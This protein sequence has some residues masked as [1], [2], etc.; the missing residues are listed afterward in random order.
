MAKTAS[1]I[2]GIIFIIAGVWGF[3][4][5]PAIGFIAAD[6]FSSIVHVIVGIVLLA[7]AAKPAAGATLKTIGIIY[8]IFAIL[9][10]FQGSS[11]LFGAFT[12]NMTTNWFYLIVGVI[13]AALGWS[14][15]GSVSA[16]S[17]APQ[18]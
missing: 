12:T 17:P 4:A 7:M 14:S 3:I 10:F 16:A 5:Q 13:I 6:P 1:W 15:K 2:F 11:V 8:I 18:A 9:G